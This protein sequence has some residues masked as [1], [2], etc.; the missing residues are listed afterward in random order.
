[1][2]MAPGRGVAE[3]PPAPAAA[4]REQPAEERS[5]R[6]R[7]RRDT[8]PDPDRRASLP[9]REGRRDDRER[10][11]VHQRRADPL[12]G[13]RGDQGR[14]AAGEAAPERSTGEEGAAGE[15]E[16]P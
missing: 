10:R 8:G 4:L 6:Q 5:D 12:R 14:R 13:A 11:R 1:R 15:E 2:A 7:E 3:E 9:R 16:P